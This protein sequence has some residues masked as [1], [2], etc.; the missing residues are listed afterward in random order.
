MHERGDSRPLVGVDTGRRRGTRR[1]AC[2]AH[3][4]KRLRHASRSR[5]GDTAGCAV[6]GPQAHPVSSRRRAARACQRRRR[7]FD[8]E[9]R[10]RLD[11]D[12]RS[13]AA[14]S[15]NQLRHRP[16]PVQIQLDEPPQRIAAMPQ[17]IAQGHAVDPR[18]PECLDPADGIDRAGLARRRVEV[19]RESDRLAPAAGGL[20]DDCA[21][22]GHVAR[23]GVRSASSDM[24]A[25]RT[26]STPM[27]SRQSGTWP[28]QR[29]GGRRMRLHG[30]QGRSIRNE[31]DARAERRVA[32]GHRRSE[33]GDD[34]RAH[35]GREMHRSGVA[36]DE[37][38]QARQERRQRD[39]IER[40]V[41]SSTGTPAGSAAR[42]WSTI[43]RSAA[44]PVSTMPAPRLRR[45]LAGDTAEAIGMPLLDLPA[46]GGVKTNPLA[47]MPVR[48]DGEALPPAR[49]HHPESSGAAIGPVRPH[50]RRC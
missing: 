29:S 49:A 2:A 17:P 38:G 47:D 8:R 39:E 20:D 9:R 48:R 36:G 10:R 11:V 27:P 33:D 35:C 26:A 30:L 6:V 22:G 21:V 5:A 14:T 23:S 16:H 34:G 19:V 50:A 28:R 12:R 1:D 18:V 15:S 32:P 24:A 45:Q 41:T 13:S 43:G 40:A 42:A 25:S 31:P 46:A 44:P 3:V 7:P 37:R 4:K